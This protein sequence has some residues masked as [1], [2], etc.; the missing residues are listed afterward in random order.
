M[1][2]AKVE[3]ESFLF[4]NHPAFVSDQQSRNNTKMWAGKGGKM[5]ERERR[6]NNRN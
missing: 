6:Q 1:K 3:K 4:D 2:Q 5:G